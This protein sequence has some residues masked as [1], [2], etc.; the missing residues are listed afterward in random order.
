MTSPVGDQRSPQR[1]AQDERIAAEPRL[2]PLD[3]T[4]GEEASPVEIHLARQPRRPLAVAGIVEN[5]VVRP[6]DSNVKLAERSRV[7]IVTSE[8]T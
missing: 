8:R 4:P 5:G 6:L 3:L 7:I 1:R 2:A